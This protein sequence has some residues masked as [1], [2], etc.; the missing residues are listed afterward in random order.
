MECTNW[1][2]L[3][4]AGGLFSVQ[5]GWFYF[6]LEVGEVYKLCSFIFLWRWV[7]CMCWLILLSAVRVGWFSCMWE[8]CTSWLVL[9]SAGG[10]RSVRVGSDDSDGL[11]PV[12][13][14]RRRVHC[15]V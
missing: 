3:F 5:V 9:F 8:D 10:R 7:E 11:V 1:L 12:Q 13:D 15:E 2:V 6:Q 14:R 4:S